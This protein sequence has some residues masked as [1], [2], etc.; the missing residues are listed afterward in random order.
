MLIFYNIIQLF[1]LLFFGPFLLLF[2]LCRSK[3]RSRTPARLGFG[4]KK[5]LRSQSL[6]NK[7]GPTFWIH[8][9]SV[10]ETTS[11]EPLIRGLRSR[12]P[13]CTIIFSVTTKSGRGVADNILPQQV[14]AI[15]DGPLDILPVVLFFH[16]TIKPSMFILIETDFWPNN[17][18]L[19][20]KKR[21]P[22]VL[23]NGRVSTNSV[24]GYKRLPFFFRPMFQS[25][26][27][28]CMQTEEDKQKM[29]SLGISIKKI[30]TLGNLK[31]DTPELRIQEK[32][33][34]LRKILPENKKLFICG[35]THPGEE[36]ILIECYKQLR[37]TF[38]DLVLVIAP[39]NIMRAN[40]IQAIA[41]NYQLSSLLRTT[42]DTKDADLYILD[43]IGELSSCYGLATIG[44]VGGSFVSKGGHNPIEPAAL[45]VPVFFGPHMEDFS[46]ISESL[47][48][49]GGAQQV[50]SAKELIAGATTLLQN[51]NE[52]KSAGMAAKKFVLSHRGVIDKH[53]HLIRELI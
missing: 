10:G 40:E 22:A 51:E 52:R 24:K 9:L 47:V 1:V 35:S 42:G 50:A 7:S 16:H 18:L 20:A 46:E 11:A 25:L 14:D 6:R 41:K 31:F 48:E 44:L 29:A 43:T 2:V 49:C 28:L 13:D 21:I 3:Y 17:L 12:F 23:V 33:K 15:I 27:S 37:E 53:I 19:L 8:A 38:P 32:A 30:F 26:S 45:G 5:T 36:E 39:R 34:E 4:L